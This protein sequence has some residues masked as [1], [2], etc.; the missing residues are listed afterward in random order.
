[1]TAF[2][3]FQSLPIVVFVSSH[4]WAMFT[5]PKCLSLSK[6]MPWLSLAT[7]AWTDWL[8]NWSGVS[9]QG[10]DAGNRSIGFLST[11]FVPMEASGLFPVPTDLVKD[12]KA[13]WHTR[14]R[15]GRTVTDID[16]GM[17]KFYFFCRKCIS[18]LFSW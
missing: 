1:M 6:F 15:A 12:E 5:N 4:L 8:D 16:S 14:C 7:F 17:M 3:K 9:A 10:R 18:G 2:E 13:Y 11:L